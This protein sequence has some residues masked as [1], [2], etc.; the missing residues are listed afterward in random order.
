MTPSWRT[1]VVIAVHAILAGVIA[2]AHIDPAVSAR[3]A[4]KCLTPTQPGDAMLSTVVLST[5]IAP[6]GSR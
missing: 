4:Q 5:A 6:P 3:C 1:A 2:I